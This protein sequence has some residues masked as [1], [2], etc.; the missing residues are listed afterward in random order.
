MTQLQG[1]DLSCTRVSDE[2]L[3]YLKSM[4]ELQRLDLHKPETKDASTKRPTVTDAG[5]QYLEE[6]KRLVDLRL[7]YTGVTDAGLQHLKGLPQLQML[8]VKGTA[9]TDAGVDNLREAL[10]KIRLLSFVDLHVI[11]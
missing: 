3:V 4:T 8:Q 11:P 10:K 2:G 5:L 9:V 7:G 1:L 6:L